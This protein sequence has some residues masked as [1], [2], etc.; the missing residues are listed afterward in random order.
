MD[1]NNRFYLFDTEKNNYLY[2]NF[3][4]E[5]YNIEKEVSEKFKEI[6]EKNTDN[7]NLSDFP[8]NSRQDIQNLIN[9]KEKTVPTFRQKKC[10][11]T[12][13]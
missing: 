5:I 10:F 4:K 3:T 13:K 12:I 2:D 8:E 9:A 6:L 7:F 1:Y 11:I